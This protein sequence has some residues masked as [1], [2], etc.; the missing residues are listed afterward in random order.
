MERI[1]RN[2][3]NGRPHAVPF[4]CEHSL[5]KVNN[6][7]RQKQDL[8]HKTKELAGCAWPSACNYPDVVSL[9][10]IARTQDGRSPLFSLGSLRF[11]QPVSLPMEGLLKHDRFEPAL[12]I[13]LNHEMWPSEDLMRTLLQDL[14]YS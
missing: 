13:E 2:R 9:G 14:H 7:R 10:T 11:H 4:I 12:P 5:P 1:L 6:F 3:A 8:L